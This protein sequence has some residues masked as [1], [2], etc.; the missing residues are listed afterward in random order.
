MTDANVALT[1]T[2]QL[3]VPL[4]IAQLQQLAGDTRHEQARAWAEAAIDPVCSRA[5]ILLYRGGKKGQA[6]EVFNHLARGLAALAHAPG[7]V[8]FAGL[9][10]CTDPHPPVPCPNQTA[11][12]ARR[13]V[14]DVDT[15]GLL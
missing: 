7:G 12:G 4:W 13:P 10:W 15:G 6:A 9:H 8:T 5:D 3:A 11:A 1:A 2:L 14:N